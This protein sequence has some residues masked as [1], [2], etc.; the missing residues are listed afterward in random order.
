MLPKIHI[1]FVSDLKRSKSS[2][3]YLFCFVIFTMKTFDQRKE[4]YVSLFVCTQAYHSVR[5]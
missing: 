4:Q 3:Q 1:Y 5:K 2:S